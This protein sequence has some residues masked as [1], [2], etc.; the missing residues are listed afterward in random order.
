M[1]EI[2]LKELRF[3][4]PGKIKYGYTLLASGK[5]ASSDSQGYL[6][7]ADKVP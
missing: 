7:K 3:D 5:A 4:L 1:L 2:P 6:K